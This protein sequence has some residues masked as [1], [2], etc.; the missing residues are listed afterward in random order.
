MVECGRQNYCTRMHRTREEDCSP[1][2]QLTDSGL[3]RL[4][5]QSDRRGFQRFDTLLNGRPPERLTKGRSSRAKSEGKI[6][7]GPVAR[8]ASAVES[9][10]AIRVRESTDRSGRPPEVG[11][12]TGFRVE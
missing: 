12:P 4:T 6:A 7:F 8:G 3:W 1:F 2:V 11:H 10:V 5:P 9:A